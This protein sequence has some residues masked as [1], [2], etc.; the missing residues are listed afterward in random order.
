M[1]YFC[2]NNLECIFCYPI[3]EAP[4]RT[5]V[6]SLSNGDQVSALI[7][8]V[9]ST[10]NFPS[11]GKLRIYLTQENYVTINYTGITNTSFTGCTTSDSGFL[12][13]DLEVILDDQ[14]CPNIFYV[15]QIEC[16]CSCNPPSCPPPPSPPSPPPP[17]PPSPPSPPP[18]SPPPPPR[19]S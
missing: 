2:N 1:A 9:I 16:N 12:S 19:L 11:S 18:P 10:I 7:I 13:T 5:N 6:S 17:P 8:N 3:N 15:S 14:L 4:T